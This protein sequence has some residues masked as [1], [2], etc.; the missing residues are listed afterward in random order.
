MVMVETAG[1]TSVTVNL[2][3]SAVLPA[4]PVT[5][6]LVSV[7]PGSG[8]CTFVTP[9]T[10]F[11]APLASTMALGTVA[12]AAV[13]ATVNVLTALTLPVS[14]VVTTMVRGVAAVML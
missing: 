13:T 5:A 2:I 6:P 7:A 3:R 8:I 4:Q 11:V 9:P 12:Y 10:G 14:V 1:L